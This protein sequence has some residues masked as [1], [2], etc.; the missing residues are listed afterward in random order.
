MLI[1][2]RHG[3]TE[4]NVADIFQGICDSPL[5]A[6]GK[7]QAK[8]LNT[9]LKNHTRGQHFVVYRSP[10]PRVLHTTNLATD[11]LDCNINEIDALREVCYGDWEGLHKSDIDPDLFARRENERFT[12]VHPGSHK[13][14]PGESYK[15]LYE[16]LLPHIQKW[17]KRMDDE[18][19]VVIAHGGVMTCAL[20]YFSEPGDQSA[21]TKRVANNEILLIERKNDHPHLEILSL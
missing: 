16:R 21:E 20:K 15:H 17:E 2:S 5:T 11:G 12:F 19:I 7:E 13:G 6:R 14:V 10:L 4:H 18:E 8:L 9:F 1:F 3:Q